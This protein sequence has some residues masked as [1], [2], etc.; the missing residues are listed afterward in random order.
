MENKISGIIDGEVKSINQ[1]TVKKSV[2]SDF[3]KILDKSINNKLKNSAVKKENVKTEEELKKEKIDNINK[4]KNSSEAKNI[5]K[6]AKTDICK[7]EDKYFEKDGTLNVRDIILR[8][9]N[10]ISDKDLQNFEADIKGL[11]KKKLINDD[12]Y[13]YGL[14]WIEQKVLSRAVK[15]GIKNTENNVIDSLVDK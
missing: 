15:I 2:N 8:F 4:I 7:G 11:W 5:D 14:R 3:Q 13:F 6:I 9:G 10:N 1:Q 12:N